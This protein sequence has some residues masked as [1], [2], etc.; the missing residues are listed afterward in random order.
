MKMTINEKHFPEIFM[1]I[2][3]KYTK[4]R[5]FFDFFLKEDEFREVSPEICRKESGLLDYETTQIHLLRSNSEMESPSREFMKKVNEGSFIVGSEAFTE[6]L[7]DEHDLPKR[8][9]NLPSRMFGFKK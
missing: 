8:R 5:N 7:L 4:G 6:N 9:I 1:K 2:N 3:R